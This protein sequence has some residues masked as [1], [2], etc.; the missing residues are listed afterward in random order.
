MSAAGL[1]SARAAFAG[2]GAP[3]APSVRDLGVDVGWGRRRQRTR[4]QRVGRA[5]LQADRVSRLPAGTAFKGQVAAGLLVAGAAWGAAVDGLTAS[6]ARGLKSMVHR[7][8]T[9]GEGARRAVEVGLAFH[10][11]SHRLDPAEAAVTEA[12]AAWVKWAPGWAGSAERL[13]QARGIVPR[14]GGGARW[15]RS[16]L[17]SADS[18]GRRVGRCI[19][20][21]P[22]ATQRRWATWPP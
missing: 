2:A 3:V 17:P 10:G 6:A 1:A 20:S 14:P 7:A 9:R 18:A 4:R 8:L 15:P 16:L 22:K 13:G 21:L 5:R 19:G 11:P 12:I